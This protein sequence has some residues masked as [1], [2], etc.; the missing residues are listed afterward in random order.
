MS[1]KPIELLGATLLALFFI[2]GQAHAL[3]VGALGDSITDE[4]LGN[5]VTFSETNLT[6]FNWLQI[7]A[8]TRSSYIN[9]GALET[10][11]TVRGEPRNEGYEHNWAR[12]GATALIPGIIDFFSPFIPPNTK[13][14]GTEVGSQAEGLAPA[15]TAGHVDIVFV[16]IGA[17]DFYVRD[18]VG[19]HLPK[20]TFALNDPGYQA[21]EADLINKIFSAV[22]T[23]LGAGDPQII[24]ALAPPGTVDGYA[25]PDLK[26]AIN[27]FNSRLITEAEARNIGIVDLF[28]WQND[29]RRHDDK[30]NLLIGDLGQ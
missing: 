5:G 1:S 12:S 7:L 6:A 3:T 20:K 23:L 2:I 24:L 15:I 27:H 19:G 14:E 4:Y 11:H 22:D 9:F 29:P 13:I 28:A 21:W 10:N 25:R 30:G 18:G 8:Q 26:K 17:N 16:G